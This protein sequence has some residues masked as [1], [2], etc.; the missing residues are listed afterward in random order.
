MAPT[1]LLSC[2]G[3]LASYKAR[4]EEERP[5]RFCGL[6]NLPPYKLWW[7]QRHRD[8]ETGMCRR[9]GGEGIRES[10]RRLAK[11]GRRH[12]WDLNYSRKGVEVFSPLPSG[13]VEKGQD[14]L[15]TPVR[16]GE[17]DLSLLQIP[18]L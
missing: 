15:E 3:V 12:I 4:E 6:G 18:T 10:K 5:E 14:P 1:P 13:A 16:R 8:W 9:G 11:W 2:T 17:P 7:K